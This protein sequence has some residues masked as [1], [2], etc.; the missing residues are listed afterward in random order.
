MVWGRLLGQDTHESVLAR[1]TRRSISRHRVMEGLRNLAQKVAQSPIGDAVQE[2]L[3]NMATGQPNASTDPMAQA[4]ALL[5]N[6]NAAAALGNLAG[7]AQGA[8]PAA[9]T[10]SADDVLKRTQAFALLV[11]AGVDKTVAAANTGVMLPAE[12]PTGGRRKTK[13]RKHKKS[14]KHGLRAKS[15]RVYRAAGDV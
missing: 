12:A 15:Q 4:A 6:P 5:Q 14:K 10:A 7:M 9:P 3:N 13:R 11:E 2:K 1:S 8:A